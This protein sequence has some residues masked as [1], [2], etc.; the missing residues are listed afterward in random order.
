[1]K[2]R[3]FIGLLILDV[4]NR[5]I[6]GHG[7]VIYNLQNSDKNLNFE[8][9]FTIFALYSQMF[10]PISV[11]RQN[12]RNLGCYGN[13]EVVGFLPTEC[14]NELILYKLNYFSLFSGCSKTKF[15]TI[16]PTI[17]YLPK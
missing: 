17:L 16:E 6:P 1:M 15:P 9:I 7:V 14:S 8:A 12:M 11:F 13:F 5:F 3:P 10:G 4:I 2:P